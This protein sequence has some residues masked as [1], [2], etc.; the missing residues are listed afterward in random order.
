MAVPFVF[1]LHL[2]PSKALSGPSLPADKQRRLRWE[3]VNSAQQMVPFWGRFLFS[4]T[5]EASSPDFFSELRRQN[6]EITYI[7]LEFREDLVECK[8]VDSTGHR[9]ACHVTPVL[10]QGTVKSG[11]GTDITGV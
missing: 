7:R 10:E 4:L 3:E 6:C 1:S 5:L 11:C 2:E 9:G 8:A